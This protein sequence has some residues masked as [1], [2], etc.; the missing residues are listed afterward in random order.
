MPDIKIKFMAQALE[1]AK[2]GLFSADPNPRVGCIIVKEDQVIGKGYHPRA[3]A[4]HAEQMALAAAGAGAKN[5][6]VY[7]TL[8]PCAHQGRTESCT[9]LLIQA[10]VRTVCVATADPN[11]LVAGKGLAMLRQAGIKV[12]TGIMDKPARELN[13][14]FI[15]RHQFGRPWVRCKIAMSLDG[16]T[17]H[18]H[19]ANT[20]KDTQ[21]DA[22]KDTRKEKWIT[23]QEAR[24]NVHFWRAR[25]SAVISSAK[26]VAADHSRLNARL[27]LTDSERLHQPLRIVL[28][29]RF[30]L[31][32]NA[33]F[34][35]TPG[36]KLWVGAEDTPLPPRVPAETE[37][38][39]LPTETSKTQHISLSALLKEL[40]AREIN[41]VLVESGKTLIASFFR[42]NLADEFI[43]YMAPHFWGLEG[44][45]GTEQQNINGQS[46][47]SSSG[48]PIFEWNDIRFWGKDLRLTL[49]PRRAEITTA[50]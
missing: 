39:R 9:K 1:L 40:T 4:Q 20:K 25:S 24:L 21:K 43:L 5:S 26:S 31:P 15:N 8:E 14:G 13:I 29:S 47:H 23:A 30:E 35:K 7:I 12:E 19:T 41:E 45:G 44:F 46:S 16:A 38:I 22:R 17:S 34:F 36:A 6:D 33:L 32:P 42:Q 18:P 3:G 37:M 10:G 2:R 11:P 50:T 48:F 28:D 49:R 27:P